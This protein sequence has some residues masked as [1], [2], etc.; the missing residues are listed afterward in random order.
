MRLSPAT[1]GKTSMMT[2]GTLWPMPVIEGVDECRKTEAETRDATRM[3][4][5]DHLMVGPR[6]EDDP[7]PRV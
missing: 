5:A 6:G 7:M 1:P 2:I 3:E 4:E